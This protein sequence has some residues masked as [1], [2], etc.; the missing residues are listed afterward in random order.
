MNHKYY[1]L[2]SILQ[3]LSLLLVTIGLG[4][5]QWPWIHSFLFGA[6]SSAIGTSV[7]SIILGLF[8][9]GLIRIILELFRL[10]KQEQANFQF[11]KNLASQSDNPLMDVDFDTLIGR[12]YHFMQTLSEQRSPLPLG[13]LNSL[14]RAEL[15]RPLSFP[16]YVSSILILLG[17]LG[18]ILSLG[19]ALMG[20]SD[21]MQSI[22]TITDMSTVI[23]GMS[24]ALSTTMTAIICYVIFRFG[25]GQLQNR[26]DMIRHDIEHLS[27]IYLVPRFSKA[28]QTIPERVDDL[29]NQ[30][31]KV[32]ESLANG[33]RT[34][35]RQQEMLQEQWEKHKEEATEAK[36]LAALEQINRSLKDGFRIQ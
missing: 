26:M 34:L 30:L 6:H 18:T 35:S 36:T 15:V 7:N 10:L 12:R 1:C 20:A 3:I 16:R 9:L 14:L 17:M 19:I 21:L 11:A 25:L 24:T 29:L 32:T 8:S 27:S 33:Q 4:I 5:W 31:T 22:E 2:N 28:S 23:E 13:S